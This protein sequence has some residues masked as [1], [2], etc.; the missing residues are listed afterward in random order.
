MASARI[1]SISSLLRN[2]AAGRVLSAGFDLGPTGFVTFFDFAISVPFHM[3]TFASIVLPYA[4]PFEVFADRAGSESACILILISFKRVFRPA[5]D[6]NSKAA[7][8]KDVSLAMG[9]FLIW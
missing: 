5:G 6:V 3:T 2:S 4:V 8:V 9:V 1:L 7:M